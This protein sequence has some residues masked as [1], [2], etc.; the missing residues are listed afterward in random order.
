MSNDLFLCKLLIYMF[1]TN[2]CQGI[3]FGL[4]RNETETGPWECLKS[5]GQGKQFGSGISLMVGTEDGRS[6]TTFYYYSVNHQSGL[7]RNTF[8]KLSYIFLIHTSKCA[9]N[10]VISFKVY[11]GFIDQNFLK[12]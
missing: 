2:Y 3:I 6:M 8:S 5:E 10:Y 7:Q 4:I 9:T 11:E 1:G 12:L